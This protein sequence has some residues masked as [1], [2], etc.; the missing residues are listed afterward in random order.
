MLIDEGT[1]W[2]STAVADLPVPPPQS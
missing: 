1:K 2:M